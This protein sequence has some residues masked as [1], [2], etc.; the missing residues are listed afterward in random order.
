MPS[1]SISSLSHS[2]NERSGM[3]PFADRHS[4]GQRAFGED[5]PA[6]MLTQMAAACQSFC[7]VSL[8]TRRRCGSVDVPAR[9]SAACFS[10]IS[11]PHP[12]QTV[13]AER[14]G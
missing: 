1:A 5:E 9:T 6:Y 10:L 12:P 14:R 2:M 8:R 4:L 3:A 13:R 11:R 7:S